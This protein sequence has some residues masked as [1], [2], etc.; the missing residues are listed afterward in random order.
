[1][2]AALVVITALLI[3]AVIFLWRR[4]RRLERTAP[5][6]PPAAP[7]TTGVETRLLSLERAERLRRQREAENR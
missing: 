1:M 3:A 6:T 5:L 4:V 7:P 2:N